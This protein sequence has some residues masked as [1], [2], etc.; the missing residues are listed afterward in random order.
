MI[1]DDGMFSIPVRLQGV[2]GVTSGYYT[3]RIEASVTN[4]AGETQ[5]SVTTL[6]AGDRSLILSVD[7]QGRICKDDSIQ[8]TL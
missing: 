4:Q 3:Y 6:S 1:G 8:L 2:E 7:T 5:T